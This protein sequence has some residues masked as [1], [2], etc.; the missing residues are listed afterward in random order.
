MGE[1]V[2]RARSLAKGSA[3]S[4]WTWVRPS[5][6]YLPGSM[7]DE[8]TPMSELG[9]AGEP[10]LDKRGQED[11][12]AFVCCECCSLLQLLLVMLSV[13]ARATLLRIDAVRRNLHV[14]AFFLTQHFN[15]FPSQSS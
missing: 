6:A 9:S 13:A 1:S 8:P 3:G 12:R 2:T 5:T 14:L 15:T 4:Y 11:P 7:E 10:G